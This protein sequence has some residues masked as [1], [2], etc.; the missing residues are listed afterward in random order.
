MYDNR[1]DPFDM[2]AA[3][4]AHV[5]E[6][7][8]VRLNRLVHG[9]NLH[10][11][12]PIA[13]IDTTALSSAV[14]RAQATIDDPTSETREAGAR[15]IATLK[16]R[17]YKEHLAKQQAREA[18][19]EER[20][21]TQEAKDLAV[22]ARMKARRLKREADEAARAE[23]LRA[24][25]DEKAAR[26]ATERARPRRPYRRIGPEPLVTWPRRASSGG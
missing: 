2:D 3:L 25:A 13:V 8:A 19:R 14:A 4:D 15:I 11:R 5:F 21:R 17:R 24:R 10:A 23:Q 9:R 26:L 6:A 20:R 16:E 22:A 18:R 1:I 7:A 12:A